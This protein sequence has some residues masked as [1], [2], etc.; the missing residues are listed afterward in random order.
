[1][2]ALGVSVLECPCMCECVCVHVCMRVCFSCP[3]VCLGLAVDFAIF[4]P[5]HGLVLKHLMINCNVDTYPS[6]GV[7]ECDTEIETENGLG[8]HCGVI[9]DEVMLEKA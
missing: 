9:E 2:C 3:F 4:V 7:T 6:T 8:G 5:H 1:M